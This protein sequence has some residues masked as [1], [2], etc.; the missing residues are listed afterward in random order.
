M[1]YLLSHEWKAKN[2]SY[3]FLVRKGCRYIESQEL[4]V[5][6]FP[7]NKWKDFTTLVC[8]IVIFNEGDVH[9][10]VCSNDGYSY[11][12]FYDPKI[13]GFDEFLTQINERILDK[14]R[15]LGIYEPKQKHRKN[16]KGKIK[17]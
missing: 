8:T 15:Y 16:N 11:P 6:T 4:F 17:K 2:T 12:P 1:D 3:T 7:V 14:F 9:I 5:Y 10:N 13:K